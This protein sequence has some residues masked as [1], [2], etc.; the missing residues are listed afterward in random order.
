M[1]YSQIS[2]NLSLSKSYLEKEKYSIENQSEQKIHD[3]HQFSIPSNNFHLAAISSAFLSTNNL[4][5]S[6]EGKYSTN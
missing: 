3:H 4:N 2:V 1:K 5:S 6:G